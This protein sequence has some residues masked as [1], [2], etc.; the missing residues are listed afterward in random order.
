MGYYTSYNLKV[1]PRVE[2]C[3][4]DL[5]E[6]AKMIDLKFDD[7]IFGD[8]ELMD[9]KEHN[10]IDVFFERKG[11]GISYVLMEVSKMFPNYA[12]YLE[13]RGEFFPT[14]WW[15]QHFKNGERSKKIFSV[16]KSPDDIANCILEEKFL[17]N[18]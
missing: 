14:D 17:K 9:I 16:I 2:S 18:D 5:I 6:I 13:G 1:T 12:F 4:N 10:I 3:D 15:V 7:I 11:D 8:F